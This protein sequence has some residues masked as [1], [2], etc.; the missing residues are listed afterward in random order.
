MYKDW[1][2]HKKTKKLTH[3]QEELSVRFEE[4]KEKIDILRI[5]LRE[6]SM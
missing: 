5:K 2:G 4:K 6:V 1:L 3:I